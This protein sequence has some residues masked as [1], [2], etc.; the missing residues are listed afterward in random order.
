MC[1]CLTDDQLA[2]FGEVVCGDLEVQRSRTLPDTAGNV[3]VG[4]VAGA[5]PTAKVA[6]LAD[7]DTTQ[8]GADTCFIVRQ[9]LFLSYSR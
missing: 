2:L 3:V 8:V 6:S 1:V 9:S 4:T 7:R 5:E